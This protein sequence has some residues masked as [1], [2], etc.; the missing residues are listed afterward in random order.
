MRKSRSK[1]D[2]QKD[3][4]QDLRLYAETFREAYVKEAAT[5]LTQTATVAI[6]KF[7]DDY[8][9]KYY[10]RTKNLLK[11][12]YSKYYHNNGKKLYGGVRIS[13]RDMLPYDVSG[14]KGTPSELTKN[15]VN[16]SWRYGY[17]GYRNHDPNQPILTIAPALIVENTLT[18]TWFLRTLN[19]S[20]LQA[21][22]KNNY[23]V[24]EIR[25]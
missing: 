7:Y 2:K 16:W 21:V 11:H 12:S 9:P 14:G 19:H 8:S 23:R 24:L 4:E 5:L 18:K 17:H 25:R 3:L 20:A 13:A 22:K 10:N 6:Q 1:R 15:V